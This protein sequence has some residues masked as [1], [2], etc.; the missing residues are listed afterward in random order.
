M[1]LSDVALRS[2][3]PTDSIQ[4]LSDGGGL[5]LWIMPNGS[6]LW[7][8]AYRFDGKQKKLSVGRYPSVGLSEARAKREEAKSLLAMGRDPSIQKQTDKALAI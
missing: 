1:P 8:L 2:A 3:K 6:K 5:Q 7:R 4:K